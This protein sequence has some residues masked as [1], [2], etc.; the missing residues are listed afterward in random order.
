MNIHVSDYRLLRL[1]LLLFLSAG[2]AGCA[3]KSLP[4]APVPASPPPGKSISL[5]GYTIQAGAFVGIN[6][7]AQLAASLQP[8]LDAAADARCRSKFLE[9][10]ISPHTPYTLEADGIRAC[11]ARAVAHELRIC[12]HLAEAA[13][14]VEFTKVDG[15]WV[16]KDMAAEW[17]K[18]MKEARAAVDGISE[19]EIKK[20]KAKI[21]AMMAMIDTV[22]DQL[23]KAETQKDFDAA[24]KDALGSM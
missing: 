20:G 15:R 13:E 24:L 3:G 22:L 7:A 18:M 23:A 11:V 2:L 14:E 1:L 21:M 5:L 16:P 8:R 4:S 10:G 6:N 17:P 19:G 12:M 9:I